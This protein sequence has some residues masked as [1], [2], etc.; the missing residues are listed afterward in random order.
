MLKV[1]SRKK[2]RQQTNKKQDKQREREFIEEKTE[3]RV[4]AVAVSTK[5][6]HKLF[7]CRPQDNSSI[8]TM[9]LQA[10][11]LALKHITCLLF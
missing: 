11:L 4:T 5:C 8:F 6:I 10:I 1:T 3:A 7:T 9:K 2:Q